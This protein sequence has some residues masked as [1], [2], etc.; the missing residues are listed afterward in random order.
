MPCGDNFYKGWLA[1]EEGG[2]VKCLPCDRTTLR[3]YLSAHFLMQCAAGV[4]LIIL[5]NY[6]P[7]ILLISFPVDLTCSL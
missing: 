7:F 1:M 6:C 2:G 5:I 3:R 4:Q